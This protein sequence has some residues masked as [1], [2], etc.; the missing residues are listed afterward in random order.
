MYYYSLLSSRETSAGACGQRGVGLTVALVLAGA[1]LAQSA[2]T[3]STPA[4]RAEAIYRQ[5]RQE[6]PTQTTSAEAAWQFARACFDWAEFATNDTQRAA[7][8]EQ[9]IKA[10]RAAL[11]LNS[12]SAPAH[13]YLA[14]NLG[15]LARTKS[16]GA[17]RLVGEMEESFKSA[18]RLDETFYHAGPDRNLGQLYFQA[19]SIGS[20]GSR[21]K[22]RIH[23]S[24]ALELAPDYPEN[25]LNWIEANLQWREMEIV[26]REMAALEAGLGRARAQLSGDDWEAAWAD[27]DERLQKI[28]AKLQAPAKT[29]APRHW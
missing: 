1:V 19:P 18:I 3:N 4:T 15:Q 23:L 8:A 28:R 21:R 26:R 22:A 2:P 14:M 29:T 16:L 13:F 9:G 7:L 6:Q 27:W 20:V 25:R 12:N 11:T 24:R 5:A 10:S 17:L